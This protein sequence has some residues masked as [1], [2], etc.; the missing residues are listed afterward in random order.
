MDFLPLDEPTYSCNTLWSLLSTSYFTGIYKLCFYL[1]MLNIKLY[2]SAFC[3]TIA[4]TIIRQRP[5]ANRLITILS[6]DAPR[7][8]LTSALS[9]FNNLYSF[10]IRTLNS[11][12]YISLTSIQITLQ[13][14]QHG[15]GHSNI[16]KNTS[17]CQVNHQGQYKSS[18]NSTTTHAS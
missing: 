13:S 15:H 18:C 14:L 3:G 6:L 2:L 1:C 4:A 17:M 5:H 8:Y 11:K 12:V 9:H 7:S 10:Q 16:R